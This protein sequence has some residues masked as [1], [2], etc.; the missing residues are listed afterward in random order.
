MEQVSAASN[1]AYLSSLPEKGTV[2]SS[3]EETGASFEQ[4]LAQTETKE[5]TSAPKIARSWRMEHAEKATEVED[6]DI[7]WGDLLDAINPLQHIPIIGSIYRAVTG[8]TIKPEMQ[9]AGSLIFGAVTGSLA[10][11]AASGIASAIYEQS[12]GSEPTIQIAQALFG[13]DIVGGPS[14]EAGNIVLAEATPVQ[15]APL[16]TSKTSEKA[17]AVVYTS[18]VSKNAAKIFT[19]SPAKTEDASAEKTLG[20]LLQEQA[21]AREAGQTLPPELVHDMML[22]TLEKYKTAQSLGKKEDVT[23]TP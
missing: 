11:S 21:K 13:D 20:A 2:A 1:Q 19:A 18:P 8:D 10:L 23:A 16:A 17:D 12:T 14:K 9:I 4:E 15:E 7:S 3:S 5:T 22:R 6:S